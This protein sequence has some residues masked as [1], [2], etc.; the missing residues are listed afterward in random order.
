[1]R[2]YGI[3]L[4]KNA[5]VQ[6]YCVKLMKQTHEIH[7]LLGRINI[8]NDDFPTSIKLKCFVDAASGSIYLHSL[9]VV[10]GDLKPA[11]ILVTTGTKDDCL[12]KLANINPETRKQI[13][14]S[15]AMSSCIQ[16]K[17]NFTYTAVF[18]APELL[19][20]NP[21]NMNE[22]KT[23]ACDIYSFAIMMYQVLFPTT[24]LFEEMHPFQFMVAIS[25]NWRPSV[26]SFSSAFYKKLEIMTNCWSKDP[27]ERPKAEF[28]CT[29]FKEPF[30]VTEMI[31]SGL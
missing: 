9:K 3:L 20:F 13:E 16:G 2:T 1:M 19:Q 6:E 25:S 28:L 23:I 5:F 12:L 26:S 27:V 17:D 11:N 21:T 29:Q 10:M 15:S 30:P 18:L 7:S 24:P 8:L 14:C 4:D 31:G 22:N